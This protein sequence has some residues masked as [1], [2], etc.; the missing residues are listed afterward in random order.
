M[1]KPTLVFIHYFGGDGGSWQWIENRISKN[2][3]TVFL[4][5]PG[6]GKT[7]VLKELNIRSYAEWISREIDKLKIKNYILIGHSMGGKLALF[8]TFIRSKALPEKIILVAPSPPTFEKIENNEKQRMLNHPNL[9]EAKITVNN[10]ANKKLLNTKFKYAVN[11]QLNVDE[12]AWKWWI[13]EGMNEDISVCVQNLNV[14]VYLICSTK[15]PVISIE[16]IHKEVL[17]YLKN[18]KLITIGRIG[19]LIPLEAPRKLARLIHKIL[20]D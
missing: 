5:L 18:S 9:D 19:H 20:K 15:D 4:T 8:T 13:N 17:P 7:E 1:D 16:S 3:E 12:N 6:F 2:Y 14:P 11:S 10:S